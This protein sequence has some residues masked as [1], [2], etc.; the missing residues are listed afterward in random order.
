VTASLYCTPCAQRYTFDDSSVDASCPQCGSTLLLPPADVFISHASE[1]LAQAREVADILAAAGINSWLDQ[2]GIRAGRSFV[3][4]ITVGLDQAKVIVLILSAKAVASDW[5]LSE[6]TYAKSRKLPILPL[7]IERFD[8]PRSWGFLLAHHQWQDAF[9]AAFRQRPEQLVSQVRALLLTDAA[10]LSADP[11]PAAPILAAPL[12]GVDPDDSP[13]VGPRPFTERMSERFFGRQQETEALLR[14]S[15]RAR[16]TLV[17][18]P[19]GAGK[20][21]LLNTLIANRLEE[22]GL[23]V[24][25]GAR[26]GGALPKDVKIEQV[27]NIFTYAVI[28]GLDNGDLPSPKRRLTEYLRSVSPKPGTTGRVLVFDQFEEIFTQRRERFKDRAGFFAEMAEALQQDPRLRIVL[29]A[30]QEYLADIDPLAELLPEECALQRF[31]LRRIGNDGALEAVTLPAA[32]YATFAPRVAERIVQQLNTIKVTLSDGT[33][34]DTPGEFIELVHLQIVCH[35]LWRSLPRCIKEIEMVHVEHA[36]GADKTIDNFVV[37]A[38][39]AFYDETLDRV[40]NSAITREH[41]GFTKE[42]IQLGCMKFVTPASTR[43]MV[44]RA[45]GRTGRLP[46]WIVEQLENS[47]LLRAEQRGGQRWYELSHD[48]LAEPVGRQID[49]DVSS[50]LFATDLLNKVLE[51]ALQENGGTLRGYFDAHREVLAECRPFHSQ[52][53]LFADESEFVFRASLAAGED[54]REWSTR[55]AHDYPQVRLDVLRDALTNGPPRVRRNAAALLGK[56]PLVELDDALVAAAIEDEDATVRTAAA[57]GIARRDDLSLFGRVFAALDDS[58]HHSGAIEALARIRIDVDSSEQ[59]STFDAALA[60]LGRAVRAR[61]RARSHAVRLREGLPVF[62]FVFVPSAALA[63]AAAAC[64]KW[65]PAMANWALTQGTPS[66]AMGIFHGIIAGVVW[67]GFIALG[68]T[69]YH[70]VYGRARSRQSV[71][72]PLAALGAGVVSGFLSSALVVLIVISVYGPP[73]LLQMGWVLSAD[74]AQFV[75]FSPEFWREI[76][77]TTRFGWVHVITGTGLGLG[78]ALVTNALWAA[79]EWRALLGAGGGGLTGMA[80]AAKIVRQL[81]RIVAPYAWLLPVSVG[82]AALG[83]YFVPDLAVVAAL[84]DA[85]VKSTPRDLIHGL[86]GD[87]MTQVI[88]AYFGIAGMGLGILTMR[89]G[90]AIEPRSGNV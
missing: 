90:L 1:E 51:N 81:L 2:S 74:A 66:A 47:H 59:P 36:A 42:L 19:S 31:A 62:L 54:V 85:T 80:E 68:V 17:Y 83:A 22:Q 39:N 69:F 10:R 60:A 23:D 28:Y 40:V 8:L 35:R 67:A 48:R 77:V 63:A 89:R 65:L 72:R 26:V 12:L 6:V 53:G 76:F 43:T 52:V 56:E 57:V 11:T 75:R 70:V 61:I 13:Y 7:R 44:Q 38:L 84:H 87:C 20:T 5:V 32:R 34:V 24:M 71:I 55:L 78:M 27:R 88:G 64:F 21:S 50:L 82:L 33:L 3:G 58:R 37:N 46:D 79:P 15:A 86:V 18:A 29:A 14:I 45:N 9:D 25:L 73:S 41:G 49:R 16:I 4:E 30:R